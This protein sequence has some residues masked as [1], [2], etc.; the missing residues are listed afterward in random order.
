MISAMIDTVLVKFVNSYKTVS[1]RKIK[2]K[3]L[4]I[5][6]KLYKESFWEIGYFIVSTWRGYN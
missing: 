6:E 5:K 3:F 1:S 4:E 2:E